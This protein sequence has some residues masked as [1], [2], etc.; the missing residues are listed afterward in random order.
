MAPPRAPPSGRTS[1][2]GVRRDEERDRA[3]VS[4]RTVSMDADLYEESSAGGSTRTANGTRRSRALRG[5]VVGR[6]RGGDALRTLFLRELPTRGFDF[7][8]RWWVFVTLPS[9]ARCW[10]CARSVRMKREGCLVV[11]DAC[12]GFSVLLEKHF[13]RM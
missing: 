10:G 11:G 3:V 7:S 6:R 2:L 9:A 13:V 5:G 12:L 4:R 1:A 8:T